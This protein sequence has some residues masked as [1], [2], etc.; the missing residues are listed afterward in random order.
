VIGTQ[1]KWVNTG[2]MVDAP[3]SR[4]E[5]APG[6]VT[7]VPTPTLLTV[8]GARRLLGVGKSTILARI[9]KPGGLRATKRGGAY[10]ID[11][12]DLWAEKMMRKKSLLDRTNVKVAGATEETLAQAIRAGCVT[13]TPG[14]DGHY[15]L[16]DADNLALFAKGAWKSAQPEGSVVAKSKPSADRD[17][18]VSRSEPVLVEAELSA[19]LIEYLRVHKD[20]RQLPSTFWDTCQPPDFMPPVGVHR[21]IYWRV[22]RAVDEEGELGDLRTHIRRSAGFEVVGGKLMRCLVNDS[23]YEDGADETR[24]PPGKEPPHYAEQNVQ[25]NAKRLQWDQLWYARRQQLRAGGADLNSLAE[26]MP[27]LRGNRTAILQQYREESWWPSRLPVWFWTT[28]T[29]PDFEPPTGVFRFQYSS[30]DEPWGRGTCVARSG[31]YVWEWHGDL[32]RRDATDCDCVVPGRFAAGGTPPEFAEVT[33]QF[34][35]AELEWNEQWRHH[36]RLRRGDS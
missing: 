17:V 6:G 11:P 32:E 18:G 5:P 4:S 14:G 33:R 26:P 20:P 34:D 9:K 2:A 13:P 36:D 28:E 16:I 29:C 15:S 31:G 27:G 24:W 23:F 8:D 35:D 1:P 25:F 30:A 3:R 7:E 19:A 22:S 10:V 21:F 12:R